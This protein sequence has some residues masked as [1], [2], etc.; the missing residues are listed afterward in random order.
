MSARKKY[1]IRLTED[2][3]K[4]LKSLV[5]RAPTAGVQTDPRAHPAD[6]R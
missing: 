4:E 6:E 2:E 1:R 3:Q 5:S